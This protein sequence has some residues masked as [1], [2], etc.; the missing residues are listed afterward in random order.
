MLRQLARYLVVGGVAYLFE[1]FCLVVLRQGFRFSDVVSVGVSFWLGL[2]LAFFLQK[3]VTFQNHDRRLHIVGR[4]A[5]FYG[6]L[7]AWNYLFTLGIVKLLAHD[8]SVYG[9]R[10]LAILL[11]TGWNFII[12]R[13]LFGSKTKN[14]AS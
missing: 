8:L 12:Y 4:Q 10:T 14:D 2:V 9:A 3:F 6:L 1:M 5:V 13:Q 7:V 11:I